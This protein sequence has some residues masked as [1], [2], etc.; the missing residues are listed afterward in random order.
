[1]KAFNTTFAGT[2]TAGE[3]AGQDLDVL[4]ASDDQ[5]AKDQV[6]TLARDG[7][8]NPVDAG[9]LK[10]ARELEAL[11]LLHMGLQSTLGTNWSSTFKI[12]S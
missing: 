2:L 3:V 4:I 10:R 6:A 9:P 11:G 5:E 7:G 12:L 1:V 8:L